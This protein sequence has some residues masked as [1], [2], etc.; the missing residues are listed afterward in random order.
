MDRRIKFTRVGSGLIVLFILLL[1]GAWQ[2]PLTGSEKPVRDSVAQGGL[3]TFPGNWD[4]IAEK[5]LK[6]FYPAQASW[7][8]LTSDKHPGAAGIKAGAPCLGCHAG[9]EETLG[10]RLVEYRELEAESIAGKK[11]NLDLSIK[12]VYDADYIYFWF[13]WG[14]TSPGVLHDFWVYDGKT[15]K[16]GTDERPDN[17][18]KGLP[19]SYEDRLSFHLD[20]RKNLKAADGHPG[21]FAEFGCFIACHNSMLGMPKEVEEAKVKAHPYLGGVLK[22]TEVQHYLLITRSALDETGG[23]DKV[24][25]KGELDKLSAAGQFLDQWMWRAGRSGPLGYS[26]DYA[27]FEFR[28]SD[29]GKGPFLTP[30]KP[31]FMFNDA[32]FGLNALPLD[33][34]RLRGMPYFLTEY[35]GLSKPFKDYGQFKAGDALP[36]R[37]LRAPDGS[38]GDILANSEY[39]D[40]KWTLELRRKL[41]T[42]NPDDKALKEGQVYDLAIA[43]HD[44][45]VGG[46]RHHV[47]FPLTLG[48]GVDADIKAVRW[49]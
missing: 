37:V 34:Y 25:P 43:V 27:V 9:A 24:K 26:D 45:M 23:W 28:N 31:S 35:P 17:V 32:I 36:R 5:K 10:K 11:P 48:I 41:V 4:R 21:G 14:A 40:G 12:A 20:E 7:E 18:K 3:F 42:G 49:R 46:R 6:L 16:I 13:Q 47:S 30:G 39:K 19:V 29:K 44:D 33:Q 22:A 2:R 15:W 8:F 38:R 1:L